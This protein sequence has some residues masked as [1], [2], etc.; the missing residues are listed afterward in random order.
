MQLSELSFL[1]CPFQEACAALLDQCL[2]YVQSRS[3]CSAPEKTAGNV[4]V[5]FSPLCPPSTSTTS[6]PSP[7]LVIDGRSLAYALEKNLEDK[8][9]FLAKQCRSVLCCRSTPLQKSM[10]VKLVR[11]KLKAMTLAIGKYPGQPNRALCKW[12]AP[13]LCSCFLW[14]HPGLSTPSMLYCKMGKH[15]LALFSIYKITPNARK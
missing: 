12:V 6:G 10:V 2:H 14:M 5:G 11:S 3:P 15:S 13:I 1:S 8:F 9:L 7:S 4:S